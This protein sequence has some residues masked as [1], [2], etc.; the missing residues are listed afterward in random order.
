V[1]ALTL[2][3]P[4]AQLVACGAKRIETRDWG[5]SFR[6]PLAIHAAKTLNKDT[7]PGGDDDLFALCNTEPFRSALVDAGWA[8]VLGDDLV[9]APLALP[10]GAIVAVVSLDRC[11]EMTGAGIA[12][13][14]HLHPREHAFGFY[15]PGRHA[16][17]LRDL[18][19]MA[20]PVECK[21]ALKL[22]DVPDDIAKQLQERAA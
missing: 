12:R 21:G 14:E 16:W 5:T 7:F 20:V 22:W 4:W 1:K 2:T 3:Q 10:R 9:P 13:L 6:G 19:P 8:H 17:V 18:R 15:A 11:T